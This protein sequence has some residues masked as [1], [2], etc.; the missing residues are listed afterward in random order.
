MDA[1]LLLIAAN[2][3]CPQPQ[4]RE[5]LMALNIIGINKIIIVQ[6]KIDLVDEKE[7]EENFKQ[8]KE[9]VK[10]TIAEKAPIIPISAQ[11]NINMDVLTTAIQDNFPTPKRDTK[12]NPLMFVAR[13]FD[14]NKPGTEIKDLDGGVLGGS[15]KQGK[16]KVNDKI[17][18]RPGLRTEREGKTTWQP[19]L[20]TI[21][22]LK[23]G[24][25]D[26]EEV[27]SG[28]SIGISTK[29]D[30]SIVKADS[31][32]GSVVGLVGKIPNV[33]YEFDLEQKLLERV[34]G[35][36][37]ELIVEPIKKGETLMLNVNSAATVGIVTTL[38]KNRIHVK[39]KVPVC[40]DEKD[41]ITISRLL[42]SRFRLIGYGNIV[43]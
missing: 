24:N 12:K 7:A 39:L 25:S 27:T 31:L 41:R 32:I 14:V 10:G 22:S 6:N 19:L 16:L 26:V 21:K 35:A 38:S 9:F 40:A 13:S 42:G 23:T 43:K 15:L 36:K 18:I 37:D 3:H 4:T 30:P 8:I 11:Q 33:W 5:H 17:E 20:T 2:E 1:A 34:V 28:G 29:L